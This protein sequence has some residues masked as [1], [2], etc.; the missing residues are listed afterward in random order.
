MLIISESC[1]IK[2]S[3]ESPECNGLV[4]RNYSPVCG[5]NDVTNINSSFA[6][7]HGITK[8]KPGKCQDK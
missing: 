2:K 7:F 3:I 8:Y 4:T 5:C 1:N 6:K